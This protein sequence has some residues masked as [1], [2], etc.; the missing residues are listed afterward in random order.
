MP[1]SHPTC[2]DC[3]HNP[4]GYCHLN[5]PALA[6]IGD[7]IEWHR[8][9]VDPAKNC[10]HHPSMPSYLASLRYADAKARRDAHEQEVARRL[11]E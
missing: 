5:P 10:S 7:S 11:G 2:G 9:P 4:N 1:S 8:P 3:P 6:V